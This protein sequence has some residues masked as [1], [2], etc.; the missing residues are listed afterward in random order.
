M[1]TDGRRFGRVR[2]PR[3][4]PAV[5][6]E[7]SLFP[8]R[9]LDKVPASRYIDSMSKIT[10]TTDSLDMQLS[11]VVATDPLAALVAIRSVRA[12]V[13]ERERAAVMAAIAGHTW[14]EIGGALGVSKQAAFQ[15]F[16][17][18][19]LMAS[20]AQM[21]KPEWKRTVKRTLG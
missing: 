2:H 10:E 6:H 21:S 17:K 4:F 11:Q 15:R 16:G 5:S 7:F 14:R 18:D 19:W 13:A 3:G 8:S 9:T 20:R 12:A 1:R